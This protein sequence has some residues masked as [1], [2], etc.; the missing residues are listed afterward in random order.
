MCIY[1]LYVCMYVY[2]YIYI[3]MTCDCCICIQYHMIIHYFASHTDLSTL[4]LAVP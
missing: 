1:I 4:S 3:M 2:I